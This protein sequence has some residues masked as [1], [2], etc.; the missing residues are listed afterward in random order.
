MGVGDFRMRAAILALVGAM[1]LVVAPADA[2][3]Q[4]SRSGQQQAN[5]SRTSTMTHRAHS[6]THMATSQRDARAARATSAS[7]SCTRNA[8]GRCRSS[9]GGWARGLEPATNVQA[10][11]CPDGTMAA[12]AH[13]HSN[14]TRCM[15]L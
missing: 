15:P 5:A 2:G 3:Q 9:T 8:Q 1:V 6:R 7:A 4:P 13:G 14:I 12:L 11:E 10:T